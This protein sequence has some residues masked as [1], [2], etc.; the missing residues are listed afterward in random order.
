MEESQLKAVV[1]ALVFAADEPVGEALLAEILEIE[2]A[3]VAAT[4]AAIERDY[5]QEGRGLRLSRVA[6]GYRFT[7]RP[8]Y[9]PWVRLLFRNQRTV[10]LSRAALQTLAIICY[11][12]PITAPE[13]EDIRGVDCSGLLKSLLDKR[14]IS[15]LGRKDVVGRPIL[16]GTAK[17]FLIQFGLNSLDDLPSLEEFEEL[18]KADAGLGEVAEV[19]DTVDRVE[20]AHGE[21]QAPPAPDGA[22]VPAGPV[23]PAAD[24]A[25]PGGPDGGSERPGA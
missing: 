10:R 3:A 20:P 13:I 21:P 7:T 15:I 1:E 18:L 24:E 9:H 4:L 17:E 22:P 25:M 11:R 14:L 19:V 8:D 23:E 2:P 6:D 5:Q 12:Q 16:Y